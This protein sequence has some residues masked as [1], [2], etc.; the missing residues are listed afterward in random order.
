MTRGAAEEQERAFRRALAAGVNWFDTAAIYGQGRSEAALGALMRTTG[1]RPHISTKVPIDTART[2]DI[3]G[4]V[5][6]SAAASLERLGLDRV[7]VLQLHNS[8]KPTSEGR[9]LGIDEV[10][11]KGGVAD[12]LDRMRDKGL[13]RFAGFTA[14]GDTASCRGA[15][16]S[17]RFDTVQ[18]YY[19][20]LNPS[21][22][23]TMPRAWS[24]QDF[25]ALIEAAKA[26]DM[27]LIAIRVLA[28]G[29][30]ATD[31]RTGREFIMTEQTDVATEERR[32]RAV[33]A[34]LGAAHG[35]R[36]QAAIRFALA[37]PDL[38]AANVGFATAA[39][40][41]EAL[42]AVG[43]GPLPAAAM[44]EIDVVYRT[45]FAA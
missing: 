6:A 44:A 35:T 14:L 36:A 1:A 2:D 9:F 18:V 21:A 33:F 10:L 23:R 19:N 41:G 37:N 45:G 17:G 25:G 27:G 24:G 43:R 26:R 5:E 8:L 32:A 38:S 3:L 22:A 15:V 30:I 11:R 34:A 7:D 31:A 29:I 13:C 28:A 42:D 20:L 16:E 12:A 4:Q 39:Q 40:L